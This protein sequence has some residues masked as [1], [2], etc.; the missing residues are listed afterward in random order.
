MVGPLEF[1][2]FAPKRVILIWE[3]QPPPC[4]GAGQCTQPTWSPFSFLSGLI[5]QL[6]SSSLSALKTLSMLLPPKPTFPVL[7]FPQNSRHDISIWISHRYTVYLACPK[8]NS[9]F[10]TLEL[11]LECTRNQLGGDI[12]IRQNSVPRDKRELWWFSA[13]GSLKH[14]G[15]DGKQSTRINT[16]AV[17]Q[18]KETRR[19]QKAFCELQRIWTLLGR[20]FGATEEV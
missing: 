6:I 16:Q 17:R 12:F 9:W 20:G 7:T 18:W 8:L 3:K 10:S 5:S 14:F 19:S 1:A 13:S 2:Q 11:H 15:T 4:A